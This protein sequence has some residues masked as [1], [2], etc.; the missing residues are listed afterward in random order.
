M[1]SHYILMTAID[2]NTKGHNTF[3]TAWVSFGGKFNATTTPFT[4]TFN[5]MGKTIKSLQRSNTV[6]DYRGLFATVSGASIQSL[7]LDSFA[8]TT[9]LNTS[10][11]AGL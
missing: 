8:L 11:L 4:G 2:E 6:G 5:G 9:R 7:T 3:A 1:D 10:A